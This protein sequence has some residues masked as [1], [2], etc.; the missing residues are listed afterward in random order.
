MSSFFKDDADSEITHAAPWVSHPHHQEQMWRLQEQVVEEAQPP[1]RK[2][3]E[4]SSQNPAQTDWQN[5]EN[6]QWAASLP[7][8]YGEPEEISRR[9]WMALNPEFMPPPPR[10]SVGLQVLATAAGVIA[11]MAAG[12]IITLVGLVVANVIQIPTI[13]AGVS[14]YREAGGSQFSSASNFRT[15]AKFSWAMAKMQPADD[16]A[17]TPDQAVTALAAA[18]PN[19]LVAPSRPSP[20]PAPSATIDVARPKTA[21]PIAP[22]TPE[23]GPTISPTRDE[24]ASLFKRG[25]DLIAVGDIVGARMIFKHLADA[26]DAQASFML[27]ST[28]DAAVI[29]TLKVVGVQADPA[30]ARAWYERAAELGSSEAKQR[31]QQS[32]EH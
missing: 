23:P 5:S 6:F 10:E 32:A 24:A 31:L 30:K 20:I 28:F 2:S 27:A 21:A 26:G 29:A 17:E 14:G 16:P 19:E 9:I 3:G 4:P 12:A 25:R 7:V 8:K 11:A 15:L 22:T 13:S 18:S 1:Q